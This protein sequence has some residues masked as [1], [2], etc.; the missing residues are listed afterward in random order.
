MAWYDFL[1]KKKPA[2]GF[3]REYE[4][5]F[6]NRIRKERLI[7]DLDFIVIDT[8]TTG[9]DTKSDYIVSY[10]SVAVKGYAIK[11]NSAKEYYLPPMQQKKEAIKIHG[12]INATEYTSL[13]DF[14]RNVLTEIGSSVLVAHHAGFD[15]AMLEKAGA[16]VGLKKLKNPILDTANLAI[17]LELGFHHMPGQV[18]NGEYSLDRLC[19][20]YGIPIEDRHTAAGDAFLTAQLLLKLLKI[21]ENK[22]IRNFGDLM[23]R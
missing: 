4:D 15:V 23:R 17:R 7:R 19:A 1:S 21:A 10:G 16:A 20:R 12:I 3:V 9:L 8:E 6:K 14:I 22:G 2:A 5:L 13:A 11:V 18:N